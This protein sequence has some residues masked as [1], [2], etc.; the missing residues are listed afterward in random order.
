MP[1][2]RRPDGL[3]VLLPAGRGLVPGHVRRADASAAARLAGDRGAAENT[4]IFA[5]TGSGKTLAAFLAC[6]DHLWRTPAAD[7]RASG[8]STSRR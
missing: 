5:P 3:D 7:A 1:D 2:A 4:L 8:S 6:L